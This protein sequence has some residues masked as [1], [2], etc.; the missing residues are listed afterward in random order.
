M[1]TIESTKT[2]KIAEE[3]CCGDR[4]IVGG[5]KHEVMS[6][7]YTKDNGAIIGVHVV[8]KMIETIP[9]QDARGYN[10][11]LD[12]GFVPYLTIELEN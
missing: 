6:V 12:F 5:N 4:F 11:L 2:T 8:V 1:E 3:L 9:Q 10:V 7:R